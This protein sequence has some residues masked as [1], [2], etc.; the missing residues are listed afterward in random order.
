MPFFF[1][2][3]RWVFGQL[4]TEHLVGPVPAF[5]CHGCHCPLAAL[6]RGGEAVPRGRPPLPHRLLASCQEDSADHPA[7][8]LREYSWISL[9]WHLRLNGGIQ[10]CVL[11]FVYEFLLRFNPVTDLAAVGDVWLRWRGWRKNWIKA[12]AKHGS[13]CQV[14]FIRTFPKHGIILI[15]KGKRDG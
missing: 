9:T 12:Q 11:W 1:L 15:F 10:E 4:Y 6:Q 8:N 14:E 5:H 13:Q 3:G 7:R 2:S